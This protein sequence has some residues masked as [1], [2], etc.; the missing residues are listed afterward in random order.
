MVL[1][2]GT[3]VPPLPYLLG[4]LLAVGAV[5]WGLRRASV[6]LTGTTVL[7]LSPWMV[8][9]AGLYV[10]Y[11]IDVVP[12]VLSPLFGSPTVYATTFVP[13]GLIWLSALRTRSP[14]K[15]LAGTGVLAAIVPIGFALGVAAAEG[16]FSP[17]WPLLGVVIAAVLGAGTW[18]LFSEVL[19][20]EAATVGWTGALVIGSHA[21]DGVSTAIGVDVL[22]FGEQTPLSR[23]VLETAGVLPTAEIIGVGWLFVVVKLVVAVLVVWLLADYVA[24]DPRGGNA[25][26]LLVTAVGLG[27]GAHNVLLFT[28]L[29][30]AGI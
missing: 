16:T 26:L 23:I 15:I 14:E 8:T 25:L 13:A 27:P 19:P 28:V 9:G 17:G 22:N 24:E 6:R 2:A 29:G 11:Q 7:A 18:G 1:P 5:A 20:D 4:V 12:G 3:T 21:L 10:L 30:S